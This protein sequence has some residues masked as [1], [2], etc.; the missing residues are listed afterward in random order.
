M[1][2]KEDFAA[3]KSAMELALAEIQADLERLQQKAANPETPQEIKDGLAMLMTR[4]QAV[5]EIEN[6]GTE[7]P[8]T[9]QDPL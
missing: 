7:Q 5:A 3:F 2:I 8:E 9:P 6:P 1:A 4:V